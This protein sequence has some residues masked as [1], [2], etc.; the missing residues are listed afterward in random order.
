MSLHHFSKQSTFPAGLKT[1]FAWHERPGALERL[2]PPWD[3]LRVIRKDGHIKEGAQVDLLMKAGPLPVP[4]R[5]RHT[6]FEQD[7]FFRDEQERGPFRHFSHTHSFQG[8]STNNSTLIDSIDFELPLGKLG[9]LFAGFIQK[10]LSQTFK[11]RHHILAEDIAAHQGNTAEALTFLISGASGVVGRN[12]TPFLTTGGHRV[13]KLVRRHPVDQDEIFW[14]PDHGVLNISDSQQIDVVVHLAGENIDSGRW[15]AEKKRR[16]I[17]SRIRGTRLLAEKMAQRLQKPRAFLSASAIGFYG[18]RHHDLLTEKS[19]M[20][21]DFISEVCADWEAAALPAQEAGI[22]LALLRIGVALT[23]K[24]GAL[25][26]MLGP[27]KFGI[28]GALG[29][30]RQYMSWLSIN[31]LIWA[32][33]HIAMQEELGGPINI[34]A[35]EPLPN[36]NFIKI[37]AAKIGRPLIPAIPASLLRLR[38]GEMAD[39]IPLAST[40]V[41]PEKLLASGFRFR[42][43]SL[44]TA[45]DYLLGT[46]T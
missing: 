3:P 12:L 34:C 35:P 19:P 28:I 39:E 14:D 20:G 17:D 27:A 24:G 36:R 5:A 29:S 45:L 32:I 31:D 42:Y 11:Y 8:Q 43:P 41:M 16:I 30:G 40:R 33:H 2:I 18:N 21:T 13:L 46:I 44:G 6:G 9:D 22:R 7:D 15:S 25:Q 37:L 10:Q 26:A 4:W 38:F 1:L 23:P